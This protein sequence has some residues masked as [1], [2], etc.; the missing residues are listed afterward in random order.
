MNNAPRGVRFAESRELES[1][2]LSAQP[3]SNRCPNLTGLLSMA[4]YV[5]FEPTISAVTGRRPLQTGPIGHYAPDAS[6]AGSPSRTRTYD[7][8][9]NGRLLYQLSYRRMRSG[10]SGLCDGEPPRH[11]ADG[12]VC[13]R[14]ALPASRPERRTPRGTRTPAPGVKIRDPGPLDDGS[15][16]A[17]A[18]EP[19]AGFEPATSPLPRACATD[20]A[21]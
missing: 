14:E 11:D 9:V 8:A 1:Q 13:D 10:A 18:P 7:T 2:R 17:L 5:G 4:T 19:S 16:G 20:C 12:A 6:G 3:T 15:M 21:N